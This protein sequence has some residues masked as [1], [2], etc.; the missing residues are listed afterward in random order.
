MKMNY[1]WGATAQASILW[2]SQGTT[3]IL[4][5]YLDG[6]EVD[7]DVVMSEG[8]WRYAAVSDNGPTLEPYF[9]E[10]WAVSPSLLPRTKQ[11]EPSG[12]LRT[13]VTAAGVATLAAAP[14]SQSYMFAALSGL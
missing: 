9:N 3:F 1:W 7:V 12:R 4:E 8:D 13:G 6:D 11:Q 10:T 2:R 14:G 5:Q